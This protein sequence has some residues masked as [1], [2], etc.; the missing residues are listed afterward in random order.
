MG[1]F[2][3]HS[4][5]W[6]FV[7]SSFYPLCTITMMLVTLFSVRHIHKHSK[8]IVQMGIKTNS[9]VMKLYV[10]FWISLNLT[11]LVQLCLMSVYWDAR[12]RKNTD[13]V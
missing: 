5:T 7:W 11:S 3:Y 8:S 9:T 1:A 4:E 2:K 6:N 13:K 10:V 12:W